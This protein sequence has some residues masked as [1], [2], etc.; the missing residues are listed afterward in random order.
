VELCVTLEDLRPGT[1]LLAPTGISTPYES[2]TGLQASGAQVQSVLREAQLDLSAVCLRTESS[3]VELIWAFMGSAKGT[4]YPERAFTPM[5]NRY[6]RP[7]LALADQ[8]QAIARK[9]GGGL[10]GIKALVAETE[11]QFFYAH[12]NLR[13]TDD[14]DTVPLL[15]CGLTPGACV[16]INTYLIASLRAAGYDAGYIYGYFFPSGS[17]NTTYDQHC[18]VI[19]RC[20]GEILEWDIAHHLKAGLG[21]SQ[22]G[23][24]PHPGRRVA[25]GYAMGQQ[26][27][28]NGTIIHTRLLA[29]PHRIN[30]TTGEAERIGLTA[31]WRD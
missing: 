28:F 31:E 10:A 8:S 12:P 17:A 2:V 7:D 21:A 11:A 26:Y 27:T 5:L 20:D 15:S 4:D 25:L 16:D 18:W 30:T 3:K 6:T 13:F 24:N 23:L 9:A 19:T 22:P 1:I 29:E 14:R